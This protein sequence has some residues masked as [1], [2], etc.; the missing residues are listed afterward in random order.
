[1]ATDS[2]QLMANGIAT[3]VATFADFTRE[4]GWSGVDLQ[5]T[6]CHQVGS[7][8]RKLMLESL[9]L[10]VARDFATLEW[11]GNTGSA[12]LPVTLAIGLAEGVAAPGDH[13]GLLGIGSGINCLMLGVEFHQ[14]RVLGEASLHLPHAPRV[15]A[16]RPHFQTALARGAG[17]GK[18]A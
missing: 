9:G 5:R 2:E 1:M 8:H 14:A 7:T 13:L 17:E 4:T 15:A 12:A 10:P 18:S 3:G 11:L 16:P 6:F